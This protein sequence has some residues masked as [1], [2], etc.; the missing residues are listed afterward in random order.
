MLY[1]DKYLFYYWMKFWFIDLNLFY[2]FDV[3][4]VIC[5]LFSNFKFWVFDVYVFIFFMIGRE[6]GMVFFCICLY[7]IWIR[8]FRFF[9][10]WIC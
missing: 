10:I 4:W 3:W 1:Y 8:D 6:I 9:G 2:N 7:L 5:W